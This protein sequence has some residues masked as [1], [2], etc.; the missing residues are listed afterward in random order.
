MCGGQDG[1]GDESNLAWTH[2]LMGDKTWPHSP[3]GSAPPTGQ[4]L[5]AGFLPWL[6][7]QP[8]GTDDLCR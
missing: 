8:S 4:V 5:A 2:P 1:G 3:A 6:S 7:P